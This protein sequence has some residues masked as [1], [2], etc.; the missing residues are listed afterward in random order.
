MSTLLERCAAYG[1]L[2]DEL[3]R[4]LEESHLDTSGFE[5]VDMVQALLRFKA[6]IQT[7]RM[8]DPLLPVA[9]SLLL[10]PYPLQH[11][12]PPSTVTAMVRIAFP[13]SF[14]A[15]EA[16]PLD[17]NAL[18]RFGIHPDRRSKAIR[19]IAVTAINN[20]EAR[21]HWFPR[22]P[23]AAAGTKTNVTLGGLLASCAATHGLRTLGIVLNAVMLKVTEDQLMALLIWVHTQHQRLG[24]TA[25]AHAVGLITRPED[26]K[27]LSTA[28]KA[29][30]ANSSAPG[31]FYTEGIAMRGRAAGEV[32]WD[33]EVS[34]RVDPDLVK[35]SVIEPDLDTF[36]GHID[37][38]L[39]AELPG[40][41]ELPELHTWWSSRWQWC[42]NGSQ[43]RASDAALGIDLRA[44]D[45]THSRHYRRMASEF[46]EFNPVPDWDGTTYVSK[47][48]KLEH[49]KTRAIFACDTRSYFAF[50]WILNATQ[51]HWKNARVLLDPGHGGTC[52]MARR[53]QHAQRGGGV[54]LMLDYDDFNS[55]H[56]TP[57][58]Q[59]LFERLC[60]KFNCP[61]WY[62]DKL[63]RSFDNM[64]LVE[65][66][67]HRRIMGTLMSG[68][69]GT[70]FIN[71]VLNAAYLRAAVGSSWFDS[72]L[73]L[74]TGDDVYVRA[75]TLADCATILE[76]AKA[77]GCRMN[78]TKQSI[79]FYNAEFLRCA[80]NPRYGVG[81]LCRAI[82][83]L[84]SG[85]WTDPGA[86]AQEEGLTSAIVGCRAV[87]NRGMSPHLGNFLAPALRY[88]KGI[89]L[90]TVAKL[91]NGTAAIAGSP[92][93]NQNSAAEVYEFIRPPADPPP[94]HPAWA[95][96]ATL[97]YLADHVSD[98]EATALNMVPV[99]IVGL[100]VTSSYAKGL[101]LPG[102]V[103]PQ[104]VILRRLPSRRFR[105][106]IDATSLMSAP[107]QPGCLS[108][109]PVLQLFGSRLTPDM[110]RTLVG[111]VGGDINAADIRREAFGSDSV[112]RNIV[113]FLPFADAASLSSRTDYDMISV[114]YNIY[115]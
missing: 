44:L 49:G 69:R 82:A 34:Y 100:M 94:V 71:S 18:R 111:L 52:G 54:N 88:S 103:S 48:A 92:V 78:P 38:I 22:K 97:S 10:L 29:L 30:G 50:S 108:S 32:N 104:R 72:A 115:L 73:S 114:Q 113:G 47:S 70:T 87:M 12:V 56:S 33:K 28:L 67:I 75:N 99:D 81:Y 58:M 86:L 6:N 74:H 35:D 45:A 19:H 91:L 105:S 62:T 66:S 42:V 15:L 53:I 84:V 14:L 36:A 27:G 13:M 109:F 39:D 107:T 17:R 83:S 79:G 55:H 9:V 7:Y 102:K 77:F 60:L 46:T 43:T 4:V 8:A 93:F 57:V 26:A 80:S 51:K 41:Y 64:Y 2:G 16:L 1:A 23:L 20:S 95:R 24:V 110:L 61:Q 65:G 98:V 3:V 76:K 21:H 68:H 101:N 5:S 25:F 85:T 37:A 96:H 90:S 31:C 112:T 40:T 59:L 11:E 63:V 89:K 106:V